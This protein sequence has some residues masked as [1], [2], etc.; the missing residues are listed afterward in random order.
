MQEKRKPKKQLPPIH[1][2]MV[3]LSQQRAKVTTFEKNFIA[4]RMQEAV[5]HLCSEDKACPQAAQELQFAPGGTQDSKMVR[6]YPNLEYT[7]HKRKH[8][9]HRNEPLLFSPDSLL[10]ARYMEQ[11]SKC[12]GL[13]PF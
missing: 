3:N 12:L 6:I 7:E 10:R 13:Q 2:I 1:K 4:F 11:T 9:W 8:S 5:L